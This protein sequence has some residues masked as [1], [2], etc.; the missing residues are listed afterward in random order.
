[1]GSHK[2]KGFTSPGIPTP[3]LPAF[4]IQVTGVI[5]PDYTGYYIENGTYNGYPAYSRLDGGAWI[6][7]FP[8]G[9]N[10]NISSGKGITF[11]VFYKTD[12]P[13]PFGVYDKGIGTSGIA[14]A[15]PP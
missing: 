1:M 10:W 12:D 3:P 9:T 7:T 6:W 13:S 4:D 14:T 8:P 11:P 2:K 15:S 5:T